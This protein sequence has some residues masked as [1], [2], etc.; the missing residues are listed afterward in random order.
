MASPPEPGP[1]HDGELDIS[2]TVFDVA[3]V[4]AV[5]AGLIDAQSSVEVIPCE[6]WLLTVAGCHPAADA[7]LHVLIGDRSAGLYTVDVFPCDGCAACSACEG[8]IDGPGT[9]ASSTHLD[10]SDPA[11]PL[12]RAAEMVARATALPAVRTPWILPD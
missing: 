4:A 7:A 1:T 8:C 11:L 3:A 12:G 2:T 10:L 6:T 5:T 9:C